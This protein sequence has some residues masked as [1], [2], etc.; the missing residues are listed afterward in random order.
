MRLLRLATSLA[1]RIRRNPSL[2]VQRPA[3]A[4]VA[5]SGAQ[6]LLRQAIKLDP[7]FGLAWTLLAS[8]SVPLVDN[9]DV[10][11]AK[12]YEEA[13]RLAMHAIEIS[14]GVAEPHAVL[15]YLSER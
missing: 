1:E 7:N 3:S 8:M 14:P 6:S 15:A 11:P 2:A 9:G 10:S 4:R 5:A 13:Q 12:G